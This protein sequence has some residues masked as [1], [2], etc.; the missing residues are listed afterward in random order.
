MTSGRQEVTVVIACFTEARWAQLSAAIDSV[1]RQTLPARELH[2]VV[3]HNDRLMERVRRQWPSLH[4]FSNEYAPGASGA[5]NTGA[6]HASSPIVAFLDDDAVAQP[7]WLERLM[8][9]FDDLSVVGAG[10]HVEA[11][12]QHGRPEWFPELFNWIVGA[13]FPGM[14]DVVTE[15]R[16]VWAE[17]MAVRYDRFMQVGGFRLHFGKVGTHSSPEDTDLCI[18]MA[19]E[20][21]RWLYV[22]SARITHDVPAER[23]TFRY[24]MRRAYHEGEGKAML[25]SMSAAGHLTDEVR[26]TRSLLPRALSRELLNALRARRM[27]PVS[28]AASMALGVC[29]AGL[30]Y[31]YTRL[32]RSSAISSGL[33][34]TAS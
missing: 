31:G 16:N 18:R 6:F 29:A 30:G 1:M 19:A 34:S 14:P 24:F 11:S 12:W 21:M 9:A 7:T 27:S 4:V 5:R 8:I 20:G 13:S 23:A 10:G 28:R 25:S 26:Y 2:V 3:D 17:N 33:A 15:V 22:P 32:L